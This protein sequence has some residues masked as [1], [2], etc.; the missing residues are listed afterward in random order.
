[1]LNINKN[2]FFA[3]LLQLCKK[4]QTKLII[5]NSEIVDCWFSDENGEHQQF[6]INKLVIGPNL[7]KPIEHS[8]PYYITYEFEILE[9]DMAPFFNVLDNTQL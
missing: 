6:I 1:M 9:Y 7:T 8:N 2:T 5:R 3:D 4:H